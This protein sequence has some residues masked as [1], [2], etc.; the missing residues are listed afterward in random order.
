MDGVPT[1]VKLLEEEATSS[2][3]VQSVGLESSWPLRRRHR[4]AGKFLR[5]GSEVNGWVTT[6]R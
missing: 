5:I 2:E 6:Q 4:Y 1:M 3:L